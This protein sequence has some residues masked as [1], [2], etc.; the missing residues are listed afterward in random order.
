MSKSADALTAADA[1]RQRLLEAAETVFAEKGFAGAS[2]RAICQLAGA[3]IAAVNYHFGDK[4]GL[5]AETIQ[6]A[7]ATCTCGIPFPEWPP[8]VHPVQKLKDYIRVMMARMLEVPRLSAMQLMMREMLHPSP[9]GMQAVRE[10]IRPMAD[11]LHGII[12]ELVPP[13][14]SH[15]RRYMIGFSIVAQCLF[16]RQNRSTAAILVGTDAYQLFTADVLAEHVTAFTLAALGY[17]PPLVPQTAE[18]NDRPL[19]PTG[20]TEE[21]AS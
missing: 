7:H 15:Q 5:Y 14:F 17:A 13:D 12:A 16:Y 1:T 19:L 20:L 18:A 9:A 10:Y 2:I 11:I 21:Q 6:R 4:E 3:N 8:E